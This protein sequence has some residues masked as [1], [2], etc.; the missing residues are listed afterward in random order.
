LP[1]GVRWLSFQS[2]SAGGDGPDAPRTEGHKPYSAT[3]RFT[4]TFLP[5]G[6]GMELRREDQTALALWAADCAERVLPLFEKERPGD[7]RPRRAIEAARAWARDE[8]RVGEARAA[9]FAA[10]A[11]TRE[12]EDPAARAAARHAAA[13]AHVADHARAAAAYA[14]KAVADAAGAAGAGDK[15]HK[16]QLR[17]LPERLRG[18][19]FPDRNE[20]RE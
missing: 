14:V 1:L 12:T 6:G 11:A 9:A 5:R 16:W 7:D 20:A 18:V 3:P 13:T 8:L 19:A 15:E 17:R 10:H 2:A 4:S